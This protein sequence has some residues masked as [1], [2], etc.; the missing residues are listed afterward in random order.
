MGPLGGAEPDETSL[1]Q[2]EY[3][4][5]V[6]ALGRGAKGARSL[7]LEEAR[8]LITGFNHGYGTRAQLAASLMLMRVRGESIAEIA[9]VAL[10]IQSTMDTQ[11]K[12]IGASI[13]WPCYAGK[14]DMLPWLLLA[15]KVLAGEGERV[16]LHGD[17]YSLSHRRHIGN[18]VTSL[19]IP[20]VTSPE[21]AKLAL[22][23][24]GI[25]YLDADCLTPLVAKFRILHQ[26]L[27][28]RS[29]FQTAIRCCNPSS[30]PVSLRSYFHPGLDEVHAQVAAA[31]AGLSGEHHSEQNIGI[32]KGVQ[33]ETEVNP[34]ITTELL[35]VTAKTQQRLVIP[36]R[37]VGIV[38]IN[39]LVSK[40][41]C[42]AGQADMLLSELWCKGKLDPLNG[43][44]KEDCNK[45]TQLATASVLS[46][47]SA[48]Y[49]LKGRNRCVEESDKQA[50]NA[51]QGRTC[52]AKEMKTDIELEVS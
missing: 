39:S 31:M 8:F 32:F 47:L 2:Q 9:G 28:L 11:W 35:V 29:L 45:L 17:P 23:Q 38:G 27:G 34:R 41:R 4:Q 24:V 18:F 6:K 40:T 13:D 7:M 48:I 3:Q 19:G 33:G 37:L 44:L 5:L 12:T 25:C 52:R 46:T 36:T 30:A 26:E 21:S 49:L 15:A 16:L 14:R 50:L 43:E 20:I 1:K 42:D 22:D 10:G 51:W